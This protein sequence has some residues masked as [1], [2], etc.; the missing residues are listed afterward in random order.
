MGQ[1]WQQL[2]IIRDRDL[3]CK[4]E[5]GILKAYKMIK[6]NLL[7]IKNLINLCKIKVILRQKKMKKYMLIIIIMKDKNNLIFKF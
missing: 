2:K 4:K 1:E 7:I 5:R 3:D 6:L